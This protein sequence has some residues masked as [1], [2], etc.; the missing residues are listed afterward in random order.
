MGITL[1]TSLEN[2]LYSNINDLSFG[3][4]LK[5]DSDEDCN[6]YSVNNFER[7]FFTRKY[8]TM[9]FKTDSKGI[10]RSFNFSMYGSMDKMFY[11]KIVKNYGLPQQILKR[12]TIERKKKESLSDG[13]K[14]VSSQ[15]TLKECTFEDNPFFLIWK[16]DRFI[17]QFTLIP[18]L[19]RIDLY[20]KTPAEEIMFD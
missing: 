19:N 3:T 11:S 15:G 20:F 14:A 4:V 13:T 12:D 5:I 17:M 10:I 2:L 16:N 18:Q 9:A 6:L 8:Q 1:N 7:Y